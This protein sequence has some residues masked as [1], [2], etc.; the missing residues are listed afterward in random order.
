MFVGLSGPLV[1]DRPRALNGARDTDMPLDSEA[2]P[3][4]LQRQR[5]DLVWTG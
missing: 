2:R 5:R 4:D 1:A 3:A